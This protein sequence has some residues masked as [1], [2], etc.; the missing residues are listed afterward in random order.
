MMRARFGGAAPHPIPPHKGEGAAWGKG[1]DIYRLSPPLPLV[2]RGWG[3]G[4]HSKG[5]PL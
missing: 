1:R 4:A 2:G 3:W 5:V